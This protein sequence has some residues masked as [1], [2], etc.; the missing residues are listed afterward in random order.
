MLSTVADS[1]GVCKFAT[2]WTGSTR[3]LGFKEFGESINAITG[4][5]LNDDDLMEIGQ[6]IWNMERLFNARESEIRRDGDM[7]PEVF[8][9]PNKLEPFK[10][11][12][13]DKNAY[14]KALD[15]YYRIL[16]WNKDGTP[17]KETR[18]RLKLDREPSHLL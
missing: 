3:S 12:K 2:P 4:W 10:G 18:I 14:E 1:I 9:E 8:Y 6:R 7:P 15:E 16:G 13:I 11:A 5:D 17:S